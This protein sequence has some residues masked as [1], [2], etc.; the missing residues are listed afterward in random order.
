MLFVWAGWPAASVSLSLVAVLTGLGAITP[1]PRGF[2]TI[3]FVGAPIA[4]VLAGILEF[5][6]L[7]GTNEFPLLAIALAPFTV[8][9]AL[10]TTSQ[11]LLWSGLGRVNLIFITVILAPS[12]PQTY[13]PQ[14]FLF[15]SVFVIAAAAVLLAAQTLIPPVS[16]EQRRI[17]L[18]AA[19]R[20]ELQQATRLNRQA[21]EEAMFRDAAR[22]GQFLSAGGAQ[23]SAALAE[24]LSCFDQS[25]MV[26]LCDTKLVPL[27]D[28]PLAPLAH[29]ARTAIVNR[30]T[31]ALRSIA[32]GLREGAPHKGSIE[33]EAAACLVRT[34]DIIDHGSGLDFPREA[35]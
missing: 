17:R 3:A 15:T 12:N 2:T 20:G 8:G 10:L 29:Q 19:A 7:D 4:T 13:N 23:D 24:M 27:V 35:T 26:R 25:A 21:P 5:I 18:V 32:H 31:P 11:N 33:A 14:T 30:D 28:G 6:I 34:S 9:A 16:D 22:I 1:N